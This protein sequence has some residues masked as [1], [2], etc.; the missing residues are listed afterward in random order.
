MRDKNLCTVCV[1]G[2]SEPTQAKDVSDKRSCE[3]CCDLA[4]GCLLLPAPCLLPEA[5]PVQL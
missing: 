5:L 1:I 4:A 2:Y 3:H